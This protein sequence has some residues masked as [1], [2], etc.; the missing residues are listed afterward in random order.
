MTRASKVPVK[1]K[2]KRLVGSGSKLAKSM[3][4]AIQNVARFGDTDIF[5]FP[6]ERQVIRDRPDE[7]LSILLQ[8]HKTLDQSIHDMP[9]ES[10]RL[11]QAVGYTGFRQ[12]TQIDPIW[13]LYLLGIVILI[14]EDIE[15]ARVPASR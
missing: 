6:I 9:I 8:I 5:P 3:H 2:A 4:L 10:E 14:G 7:A 15:A 13:N 11:L 1:A 12:G